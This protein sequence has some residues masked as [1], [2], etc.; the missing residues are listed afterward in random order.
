V[1][2]RVTADGGAKAGVVVL[3]FGEPPD[4]AWRG[5]AWIP[6]LHTAATGPEGEAT[7]TGVR[8]GVYK[9]VAH[10]TGSA[11]RASRPFRCRGDGTTIE[12][13]LSLEPSAPCVTARVVDRDGAPLAHSWALLRDAGGQG[14][15]SEIPI[16]IDQ[17]GRLQACPPAKGRWTLLAG[18]VGHEPMG[19]VLT[20]ADAGEEL[21]LDLVRTSIVKG[22]VVGPDGPAAGANVTIA[23]SAHKGTSTGVSDKADADGRFTLSTGAGAATVS[24]WSPQ[25]WALVTLSPRDEGQDADDLVLTLRSGRTINGR[26]VDL[27]GA[28]CPATPVCFWSDGTGFHGACV[29]TGDGGRFV[30]ANV[31]P[32]QELQLASPAD[33]ATFEDRLVRV[34][35]GASEVVIVVARGGGTGR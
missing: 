13:L 2:V 25:G 6:T 11:V 5:R 9:P 22:R 7:M 15:G 10:A 4:D 18:A 33:S 31:P 32:G 34:A 28:P 23:G 20:G 26:C 30:L 16:A 12:V 17:A 21:V 14:V 29:T 24:A 1:L 27:S 19:K 8:A 35:P 3:L